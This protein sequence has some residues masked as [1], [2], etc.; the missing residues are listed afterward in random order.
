MQQRQKGEYENLFLHDLEA[1]GDLAL[2]FVHTLIG[3]AAKEL[4]GQK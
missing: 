3:Q 2:L 4:S 1:E